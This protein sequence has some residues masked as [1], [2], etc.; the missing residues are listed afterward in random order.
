MPDNLSLRH[1]ED[2]KRISS[3]P[4]ER[5][6]F[7]KKYNVSPEMLQKAIDAVGDSREKV[8]NWLSKNR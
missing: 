1:P 5:E 3:Q 4:Y 6:A 8:I 2:G 7:C